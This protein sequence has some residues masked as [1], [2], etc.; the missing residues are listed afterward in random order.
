MALPME[1]FK[2]T[3]DL[4]GQS[5]EVNRY[6]KGETLMVEGPKG[7]TAVGV[8]G[9]TLGW[10]KQHNGMLKNGYPKAWRKMG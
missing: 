9:Y 8:D 2:N 4:D 7:W 3:L 6:L 5:E 1:Q 10:G